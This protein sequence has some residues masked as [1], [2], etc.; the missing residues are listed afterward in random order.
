MECGI[1]R[2]VGWYIRQAMSQPVNMTYTTTSHS[3][4]HK[5]FFF[6][7]ITTLLYY[8]LKM[9]PQGREIAVVGGSG[10]IGSRTVAALLSKDIHTVTAISR[11]DSSATFPPKVIVKKGSYDDEDF[12]VSAL[13]GQDVLILQ[14]G[15]QAMH[16]QNPLIQA[17]AKAGVKYILPV[18]FGSD[19]YATK[20]VESNPMLAQKA[21]RR[22]LV[23]DLGV[24]SWIAVVNNPWFDWSLGQGNW[25]IDIKNRKAT[26]YGEGNTKLN[27]ANLQRTADGTATLLSLPEEELAAFK[28]KPFYVTSLYVTQR[29]ILEAVQRA[30]NTTDADW[31][32]K[33]R[34]FDE[35]A[36]E[37]DEEVKKGNF[38][39]MIPKFYSSH[40]REGWG[41][42]FNQKVDS[43]KLGLE[44][45]N[46]DEVV[47]RV[48]ASL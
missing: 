25:G 21:E 38:M 36:K 20:L 15:H 18:E 30:T 39:A 33:S 44:M 14:F 3:E 6:L 8:T 17:A 2:V 5:N 46:I 11:T 45:E 43:T 9:A 26:I 16:L 48:V 41:G 42:D 19:P 12:L 35:V 37:S 13:K 7:P 47:K 40:F 29:E 1:V 28:N 24:G 10:T 31:E 32:I 4:S 22:Q 23:E 27:T 34:D